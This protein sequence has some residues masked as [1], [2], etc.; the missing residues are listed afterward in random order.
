MN[1]KKAELVLLMPDKVDLRA[2]KITRDAEGHYIA[3]KEDTAMLTVFAPK[4]AT[5]ICE[6]KSDRIERK[7]RKYPTIRVGEFLNNCWNA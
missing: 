5:K 2:K 6:A 4:T 1:L 7:N 3:I